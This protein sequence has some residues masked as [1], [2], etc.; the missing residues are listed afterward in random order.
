MIGYHDVPDHGERDILLNAYVRYI[1][2]RPGV[3]QHDGTPNESVK[4]DVASA[5][6]VRKR[7]MEDG[8]HPRCGKI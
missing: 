5:E 4:D 8:R 3:C 7:D 1:L 6:G 2:A